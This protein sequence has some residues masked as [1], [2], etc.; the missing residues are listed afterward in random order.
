MLFVITASPD[1]RVQRTTTFD[2]NDLDAAFEEL[3]RQYAEQGGPDQRGY[4]HAIRHGDWD[5]LRSFFRPDCVF[6]DHRFAGFDQIDLESFIA[7]AAGPAGVDLR[8]GE[9]FSIDHVVAAHPRG[10]VAVATDIGTHGE[11]EYEVNVL[12][13]TC[14]DADEKTV[15]L[16][17]Y[18]LDH[19]D[20]AVR[21]LEEHVAST[22]PAVFGNAAWRAQM[23]LEAAFNAQDFALVRAELSPDF[24]YHDRRA[25]MLV[26]LAGEE[27]LSVFR[28][29]VDLDDF[30]LTDRLVEVRGD[31]LA[32]VEQDAVFQ[33]GAAGPAEITTLTVIEAEADGL[34]RRHV[35]FE[36]TAMDD[37]LAELEARSCRG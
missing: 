1:G 24:T 25:T 31:R 20:D 4:V 13:V 23:R 3:D 2:E 34:T 6:M 16:H 8:P 27:A 18:D 30:H 14:W 21:T 26:D 12:S 33:D 5:E 7:Y 37:A 29:G 11:S 9:R 15:A 32:L 17:L 35:V 19:L 36:R 10:H 28:V 22:T